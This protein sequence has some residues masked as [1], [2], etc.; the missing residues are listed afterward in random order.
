[1]RKTSWLGFLV[2][3]TFVCPAAASQAQRQS[4]RTV[5]L[6][7]P[8]RKAAE[9]I[10]AAQLRDYLGFIASDELEGR[11]TPSRGLDTAA[12]YLASHLSRWGLKPAGDG[13]SYFQRIALS[14]K[15]LDAVQTRAELNGQVL[16]YGED[17]LAA[18]VPGTASGP[19]VYVG[20]GWV[21]KSRNINA[22][23][24]VDVKDK[25]LIVSGGRL[26]KGLTFADIRSGKKGEDWDDASSYALRNG[27]KGILRVPN[28]QNLANWDRS[29]R[30]AQ[31]YSDVVMER[32]ETPGAD[33]V[34]SLTLSPALFSTLMRGEP[35]SAAR[36]YEN[37]LTGEAGEAFAL[38][39]DKRFQFTVAVSTDKT[40]TQNVVAVVEGSDPRLKNEYVALGAHY[41]HVGTGTPVNGDAIYNGA[42]DDG[43][44]TVALL[45]MAESF[46]RGP[47]PKRSILFVWHCGE[48]LGLWGS[49]YFTRFPTVPLNGII[50]QLNIDMIGRSKR[51]GDTRPRNRSLSGPNE[52]YVIGSKMMSTELG[53]LS[54]RVN[55][56]YLNLGFNYA[57]DDPNDPNR[58]FFRSDHYS[59]AQKGIPIIFY[60]D[61][62]H[63]DYHRV[64]D[65][66]EKIDYQKM[67]KVT[68]TIF[69]TAWEL[70]N[71]STRPRIDKP[72]PPER[73]GG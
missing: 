10:T 21:V 33:E 41:D 62:V 51:P 25:I 48:E 44:G 63:E 22:Y 20:H 4:G 12:K 16:R 30:S 40:S 43:S 32:F 54:E 73:S 69:L 46:A 26:P 38:N 55:R 7:A 58:F 29:R 31:E 28:F 56:S 45:A 61:G 27:A 18:S 39:P 6:S 17:F 52:V 68:R 19:L 2:I 53:A 70:A 24:G 11:D 23:A 5:R 66:A 14:R 34:P 36:L 15:K 67:E 72:L 1:M 42:D 49:R 59:Y 71:A 37:G 13:N 35:Q 47:R 60:F 50:T 65:S 64:T 9:R 8:A 3:L 57:Y